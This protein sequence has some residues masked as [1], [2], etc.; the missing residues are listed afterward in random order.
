MNYDAEET[1]DVDQAADAGGRIPQYSDFHGGIS[2]NKQ[3]NQRA[4]SEY[5]FC[6]LADI[7]E[8]LETPCREGRFFPWPEAKC[9][10][11]FNPGRQ[12][13]FC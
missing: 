8:P 11:D 1:E 7:C 6:V 9:D 10:F 3:I 5:L 13:V 4:C 12:D 2:I